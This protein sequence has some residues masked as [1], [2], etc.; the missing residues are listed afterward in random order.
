MRATPFFESVEVMATKNTYYDRVHVAPVL[1]RPV[2]TD[3]VAAAVAHVAVGLPMFATLEVAGPE[4]R[5]LDD[6]T[7]EVLTARRDKRVVVTDVHA[8]YFGAE[9]GKRT[10]LPRAHAHIGHTTFTEWLTQPV[11]HTKG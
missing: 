7:A 1:I 11:V 3:D 8:R 4:E 2:S 5:H 10:L 9:M 6:L